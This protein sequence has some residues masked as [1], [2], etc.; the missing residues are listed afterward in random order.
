MPAQSSSFGKTLTA[1]DLALMPGWVIVILVYVGT[2]LWTI[3]MSFTRSK[4]LPSLDWAGIEQYRR[5]FQTARWTQ[6]LENLA[7]LGLGFIAL[8][9]V[10]G[11]ALAVALDRQIRFEGAIRTVF[12]YPYAMSFIVTGVV[13]RWILD[14]T[15][16]LQKSL[17]D[18]G[19]GGF[20]LD[21]TASPDQAIYAVILAAIW[22]SSGLVMAL[23]LAGLRG[24]DP[25]LWK[26]IRVDGIPVWRAYLQIILPMLTPVV[27]TAT[28]LLGISVVKA[29]D[30]VVALTGGGPGFATDVPGK[31]IM[32]FLFQ[33]ANLGLASA[34]ACTMLVISAALVGPWLYLTYFV[35]RPRA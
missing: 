24:I 6:S 11:F 4:M 2:T 8:S 28:V 19:W 7:V 1:A 26:A 18:W 30:L 3:G 29:Y 35:R 14:P 15:L 34:A 12:L 13:W 9:L 33:R 23:M 17:N 31:F 16:G 20:R 25:D 10:L 5:L 32:D 22:Q 21:W 27:V